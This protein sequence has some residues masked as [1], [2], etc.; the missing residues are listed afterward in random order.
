MTSEGQQSEFLE[1]LDSASRTDRRNSE[2]LGHVTAASVMWIRR[3]GQP[4]AQLRRLTVIT[5]N[6]SDGGVG[7]FH[8][9]PIAVGDQLRMILERPDEV[10]KEVTVE[11]RHCKMIGPDSYLAGA[12]FID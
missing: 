3:N 11:V 8:N 2:R 7:F 9:E 10:T 12:Q 1:F 5:R 4:V 6:Y